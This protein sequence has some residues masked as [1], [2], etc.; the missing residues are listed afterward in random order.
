MVMTTGQ[1]DCAFHSIEIGSA[2]FGLVAGRTRSIDDH[3]LRDV[4]VCDDKQCASFSAS[5]I[6]PRV[7]RGSGC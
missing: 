7:V 1:A 3:V 6:F 4:R 2:E 5:A